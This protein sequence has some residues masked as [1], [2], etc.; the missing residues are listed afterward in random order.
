LDPTSP[1]HFTSR[2][3]RVTRP[4]HGLEVG[5]VEH[6]VRLSFM[7]EDMVDHVCQ[8][9]TSLDLAIVH[10]E[11]V[12]LPEG[13]PYPHPPC[14]VVGREALLEASDLPPGVCLMGRAE[15]VCSDR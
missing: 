11:G 7:R 10:T 12:S 2:L 1:L 14:A 6:Q 15:R 5:L 4:T 3:P 13:I 9:G 8:A